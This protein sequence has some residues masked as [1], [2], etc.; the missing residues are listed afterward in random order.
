TVSMTASTPASPER[1]SLV[2]RLRDNSV[3]TKLFAAVAIAGIAALLVG[4]VGIM[5]LDKVSKQA[6]DLQ[7]SNMEGSHQVAIVS[8]AVDG[9]RMAA[10]DMLIKSSKEDK[11][12]ALDELNMYFAQMGE[13]GKAYEKTGLDSDTRAVVASLNET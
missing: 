12:A 13:A 10:R 5:S 8:G 4:V 11:Q 2:Q 7:N 9:M 1:R 3:R 6:Q